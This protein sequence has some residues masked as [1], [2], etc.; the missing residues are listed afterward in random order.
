MVLSKTIS[1]VNGGEA[2]LNMVVKNETGSSHLL[3]LISDAE[4]IR[5]IPDEGAELPGIVVEYFDEYTLMNMTSGHGR[6]YPKSNGFDLEVFDWQEKCMKRITYVN[7]PCSLKFSDFCKLSFANSANVSGRLIAPLALKIFTNTTAQLRVTS[8]EPKS[9]PRGDEFPLVAVKLRFITTISASQPV[10][11]DNLFIRKSKAIGVVRRG[12]GQY[13]KSASSQMVESESSVDEVT[14]THASFVPEV[15]IPIGSLSQIPQTIMDLKAQAHIFVAA[16]ADDYQVPVLYMRDYNLKGE[17]LPSSAIVT[18]GIGVI[19]SGQWATG[20][21]PKEKSCFALSTFS[22]ISMESNTERD[23][24]S[25]FVN[26]VVNRN[27]VV[28]NL[29]TMSVVFGLHWNV[30][31]LDIRWTSSK[32]FSKPAGEPYLSDLWREPNI[33][34]MFFYLLPKDEVSALFVGKERFGKR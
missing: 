17:V 7:I 16:K 32:T 25:K 13:M 14:E 2:I 15:K 22:G 28:K 23:Y 34:I 33:E 5:L 21:E 26:G 11:M 6:I 1:F 3:P 20:I 27:I 12:G 29:T 31:E 19:G 8:T 10:E 9:L 4:S 24:N 18:D 30:N